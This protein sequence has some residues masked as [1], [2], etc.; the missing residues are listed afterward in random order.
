MTPSLMLTPKLS[1]RNHPCKLSRKCCLQSY[2]SETL[3]CSSA[4]RTVLFFLGGR[5]SCRQGRRRKILKV[6]QVTA[7]ENLAK[8]NSEDSNLLWL[9]QR[10]PNKQNIFPCHHPTSETHMKPRRDGR[11]LHYEVQQVS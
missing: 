4:L 1:A 3:S 6:N 10:T 7:L 2:L 11:L 8:I 5:L 9:K